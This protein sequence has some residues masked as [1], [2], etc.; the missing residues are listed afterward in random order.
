MKRMNDNQHPASRFSVS[1]DGT[2]GERKPMSEQGEFDFDAPDGSDYVSAPSASEADPDSEYTSVSDVEDTEAGE[3]CNAS[4]VDVDIDAP[5]YGT[6]GDNA[7]GWKE[8]DFS[9]IDLDTLTDSSEGGTESG[10]GGSTPPPHGPNTTSG[11]EEAEPERSPEQSRSDE[12]FLPAAQNDPSSERSERSEQSKTL[13]SNDWK[14]SDWIS[15]IY[16]SAMWETLKD[17][18]RPYSM[19]ESKDGSMAISK[20]NECFFAGFVILGLN[21]H[22]HNGSWYGYCESTGTWR[23]LKKVA[24][25][26]LV[27][28]VFILFGKKMQIVQ[29]EDYLSLHFV[30]SVIGYM[31]PF[32]GYENIFD[33]APWRAINVKNGTITVSKD[34]HIDFHEHSPEFLC[35]SRIETEYDPTADYGGFVSEAFGSY[36]SKPDAFVVQQYAGQCILKRNVSQTFL[37]ISGASGTGKSQIVKVI[38]S[39]V[40]P[41]SCEGLRTGMLRERFELSR[42]EGKSLLTAVD[43]SGDALMRKGADMLKALTG[44]DSIT[45][46]V[47]CQNEHPKIKGV[48]SVILV[49]NSD[50]AVS[51][52]DDRVAW[53]RRMLVV[54][55]E[56]KA[57]K[58]RIDDFAG[59]LLAKYSSAVLNWMLD[60]AAALFQCG[61]R[62]LPPPEMASRID[63]ILQGSDA[64][65]AFVKNRVVH[66]GNAGDVLF[67]FALYS[68]F[69][70]SAYFVGTASKRTI[71]TKLKKAMKD[72]FG[73]EKPRQD[74]IG[75]DGKAKYGY[76]GYC[77]ERNEPE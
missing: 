21:L 45:T 7:E 43:E 76:V 33:H 69:T 19:K 28:N 54:K 63:E 13:S 74:L 30:D 8:I 65:Y 25:R 51:I 52:D 2:A 9:G 34:G 72:V 36:V 37:V 58:K 11:G 18:G 5:L 15:P 44:G 41:D 64:A 77:L 53:G 3:T 70:S 24:L 38:E 73:V 55:Y 49:S 66:T 47:K 61:G 31:G 50:L 6:E 12:D 59:Y 60:G 67:S 20:F 17:R 23:V 46:E 40:G 39:V 1:T 26:I 68:A 29:I 10:G 35:R 32:P 75:P 62:I 57:P 56:G 71:Q 48:F 4:T 22:Y 27:N 42:F 14:E 16:P